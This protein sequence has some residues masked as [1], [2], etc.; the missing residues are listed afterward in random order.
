MVSI[1]V[2]T[3][4]ALGLVE[5]GIA[6]KCQELC[7]QKLGASACTKKSYCRSNGFC[8]GLSW[9]D[10]TKTN[11]FTSGSD[12][13]FPLKVSVTCADVAEVPPAKNVVSLAGLKTSTLEKSSE[14]Y[15]SVVKNWPKPKGC[16]CGKPHNIKT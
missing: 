14:V 5:V 13:Q 9:T 6:D 8:H 3:C 16:N 1:I 2:K 12:F 4:I 15:C 10:S 11:V 7:V